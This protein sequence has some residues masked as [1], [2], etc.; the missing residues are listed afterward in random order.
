VSQE[1]ALPREFTIP[2]G[3]AARH[4]TMLRAVVR[5]APRRRRLRP[6]VLVGAA[7]AV[8]ASIAAAATTALF[9]RDV[10]R[11]DL[12]TRLT[13]T[14]RTTR[15][16]SAPGVCSPPRRETVGLIVVRPSDSITFV[17]PKGWL[18]SV[19][20]A[21]GSIGF[22][23]LSSDA[24]ALMRSLRVTASGREATL[25]LS[26][27]GARRLSWT[28]GEGTL[29]VIDERADGTTARTVLRS[30]DV[31][32]LVP[33]SLDD[34][35]LTPDK[36]V[37]ID[38]A[39]GDFPVWIYPQRNEVYVASP[40]WR[41]VHKLIDVPESVAERYGLI[42]QDGRYA[43]PLAPAGGSWSYPIPESR[44]RTVEWKAGEAHVTVT[45]RESSG[46]VVGSETLGIGRRVHGG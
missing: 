18:I 40:P 15:D 24:R 7:F 39:D 46:R 25:S 1:T 35:P 3:T 20:P 12:D 4:L 19:T 26:G 37:T 29:T 6:L 34:Q 36:A 2:E 9:D 16:C 13:T 31:A 30:G 45:D 5:P 17:D 38:L 27:G 41:S 28:N 21:T 32:A 8:A 33:S 11:H 14:T 23:S 22:E 44:T 42:R 10:T 43:V